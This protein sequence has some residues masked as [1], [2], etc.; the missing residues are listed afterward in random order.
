MILGNALGIGL[1]LAQKYFGFLKLD[2][3]NYYL[4]VVPIHFDVTALVLINVG[5]VVL[6][7]L[8][9]TLPTYLITKINPV[10]ILRF[11]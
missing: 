10:S 5:T 6:T 2:E 3:E 9:M 1:A 11:D 4:S 7:L 8:L